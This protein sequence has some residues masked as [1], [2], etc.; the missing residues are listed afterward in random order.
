MANDDIFQW[1]SRREKKGIFT[2]MILDKVHEIDIWF[3]ECGYK[4]GWWTDYFCVEHDEYV[5]DAEH[6]DSLTRAKIKAFEMSKIKCRHC[7]DEHG[8]RRRDDD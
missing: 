5:F 8:I 2:C 1:H 3:N 6:H 7:Y 4:Y